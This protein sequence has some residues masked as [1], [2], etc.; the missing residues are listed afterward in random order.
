M[1][2]KYS[3]DRTYTYVWRHRDDPETV[4]SLNKQSFLVGEWA[5]RQGVVITDRYEDEPLVGLP[6]SITRGGLGRL[7]SDI[8]G[9]SRP[10]RVVLVERDD[11]RLGP[12]NVLAEIRALGTPVVFVAADGSSVDAPVACAP[13]SPLVKSVMFSD[14]RRALSRRLVAGKAASV[15][16]GNPG[17]GPAPFGYRREGEHGNL[18]RND[19]EADHLVFIFE[20]YLRVRSIAKVIQGLA[21]RRCSRTRMGRRWSSSGIAMILRNRTY[22]GFVKFGLIQRRGIHAP[23]IDPE[24]FRR[25]GRILQENADRTIQAREKNKRLV[26]A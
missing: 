15:R 10:A 16:R 9:S 2:R 11:Y 8:E 25:V 18:V 12:S 7:L 19:A 5:E 1:D 14:E 22:L 23:L 6:E 3:G 17:A 21:D 13:L 26:S 24:T 4:P 20:E